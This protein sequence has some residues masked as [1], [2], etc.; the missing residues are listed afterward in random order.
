LFS[1]QESVSR[2][3]VGET[4]SLRDSA[5]I[6]S[7]KIAKPAGTEVSDAHDKAE[8]RQP[9]FREVLDF[10]GADRYMMGSTYLSLG[11]RDLYEQD[12]PFAFIRPSAR[13]SSAPALGIRQA[14]GK[15]RIRSQV[16]MLRVRRN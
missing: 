3:F 13:G 7:S 6:P 15:D 11:G 8:V 1:L 4:Y 10:I 14:G 12:H 9:I 5:R 2:H 16:C